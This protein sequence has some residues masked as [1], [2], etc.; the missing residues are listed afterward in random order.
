MRKL[1][2]ALV[3]LFPG[4]P[5]SVPQADAY[6]VV[7]RY[8]LGGAGG[9]DYLTLDSASRRLFIARDS[10]VTVINADK[11]TLVVEVP[12][13]PG[14]HGVALAPDLGRAFASA[15]RDQSVRMFEMRSLKPLA[16]VRTT[17]RD[18][19]AVVY[20]PATRRVFAFNAGSA[21]ATAIDATS[22]GVVGTV[23]LGGRPEFA[24][25]PGDGRVFVNIQ[26]RS[27]LVTLDARAL[28]VTARW[29]L[30]PC[31]DPTGLALDARNGRLFVG[32]GNHLMAVVDAAGGRIVA[33]LPIGG[34]VDGVAFDP[35]TGLAF[36]A[37]GEGTLSVVR[38]VT[39]EHF[40]V[41]EDVP[42]QWGARTLALDPRTHQ[43]FLAT[44][45][46]GAPASA[47]Q[48]SRTRRSIVPGTFAILVMGP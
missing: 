1:L 21:S 10:R 46:F 26:D 11:G 17:G 19:D 41:A 20:E 9:W 4:S 32:C 31:V 22:P 15:G 27:E 3:A 33:T 44:A 7:R 29:P 16:R 42:T 6:H 28:A 30:A 40:V 34:G 43:V 5:A 13:I 39:R 8:V 12:D 45:E 2:I 38:E 24:V 18:P 48:Q 47:P 23:A 37:N 14:V 36:S 35:A 25:A